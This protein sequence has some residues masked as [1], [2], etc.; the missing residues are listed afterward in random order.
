MAQVKECFGLFAPFLSLEFEIPCVC[1]WRFVLGASLWIFNFACKLNIIYFDERLGPDL[2]HIDSF[3]MGT[4][5][6][7]FKIPFIGKISVYKQ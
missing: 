6:H 2:L 5:F 7:N 1:V 4:A 3:L